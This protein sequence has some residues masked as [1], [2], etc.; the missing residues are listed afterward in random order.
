MTNKQTNRNQPSN[1][2]TNQRTDMRAHREVT[3]PKDNG[4]DAVGVYRV[5][6]VVYTLEG[7]DPEGSRIK[8]GIQVKK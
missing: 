2:P 3:F 6:S 8:F 1:H 7:K 5:G 4:Y